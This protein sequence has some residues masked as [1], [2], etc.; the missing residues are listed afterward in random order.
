M[1]LNFQCT[2]VQLHK[3]GTSLMVQWLRIPLPMK[4]KRVQSLVQEISTC[5]GAVKPT[6]L[7][8]ARHKRSHQSE[9]PVHRQEVQT[10][11]FATRES[12]HT[13]MKIQHSQK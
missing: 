6:C 12:P 3:P 2:A 5:L 11:L 9:K 4:G 1:L 13:A 10:P 7:A 8:P